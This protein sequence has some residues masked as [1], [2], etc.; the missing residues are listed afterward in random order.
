MAANFRPNLPFY[1]DKAALPEELPTIEQ[2]DQA[3]EELSHTAG[4]KVVAIGNHFVIKYGLQVDLLEGETMLFLKE[5]TSV[6]VPRIY[7]LFQDPDN[8]QNYI[9][10]ERI[11]GSTLEKEWPNLD[12][13]A[14][15]SIS[16][17]L[18]V[19][20]E[21]MRGLKSPGKF[22]AL[23]HR[24][25][26]DG[27][28]WTAEPVPFA[29]GP[30]ESEHDLNTAII[31]NYKRQGHSKYK[32]DYYARVFLILFRDHE[33]TF[34]HGDFQRKNIIIRRAS[35]KQEEREITIIDWE[36]SGWYPSYWEY[37]RAVYAGSSPE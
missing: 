28:F 5:S 12:E 25:L 4:C 7:A 24:A 11:M 1:C 33:P 37:S 36:F 22:C 20:V 3:Q 21:E 13:A 35:T 16:S 34:T 10:M 31:A 8:K 15:D 6:P 26:T 14:K 30:F 27:I 19:A 2:I 32:A 23:G 9:I 29:A 17:Q 18:R